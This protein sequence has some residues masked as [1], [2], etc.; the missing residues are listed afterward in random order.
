MFGVAVAQHRRRSLLVLLTELSS[1]AL[2][3]TLVPA[4]PLLLARHLVLVGSVQ[5]PEVEEWRT[6]VPTEVDQAYRAAGAVTVRRARDRTADLLR[7][8][9]AVVVDEPPGKLAARLA[10]AYLDVKATGRL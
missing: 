2:A 4:L 5:D 8:M 10:D 1:E 6:T 9:G 7:Q 3:E